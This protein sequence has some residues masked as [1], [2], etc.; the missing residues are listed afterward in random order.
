M[1]GRLKAPE[2]PRA[3]T[4][5]RRSTTISVNP[6]AILKKIISGGQTGVDTAGLWFALRN[7]L[8]HGGWCPR[9]RKREDGL[10]P[11]RFRLRET[12]SRGYLQRTQWNVRDSDGTII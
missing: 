8:L 6:M 9:G 5:P 2:L 3:F 10:I 12:P 1:S 11:R 4:N 7:G